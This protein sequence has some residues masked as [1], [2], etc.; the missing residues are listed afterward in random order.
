MKKIW[1]GILILIC[2]SF[3]GC[4]NAHKQEGQKTCTLMVECRNAVEKDSLRKDLKEFLPTDGVIL[5]EKKVSFQSGESVYKVLERT[6]KEEGILMEAS[7][8]G[9]IAYIEG[10]DNLYEFECGDLSGWMYCVNG[11][12]PN[13]G[14]SSYTVKEGDVI[15][16]HYTCDLGKDLGQEYKKQGEE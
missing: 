14:C 11:K 13:V 3:A 4:G 2:V 6:M 8:T 5:K 7:F 15:E 9:D 10:I 12:Y 1:I 16:W